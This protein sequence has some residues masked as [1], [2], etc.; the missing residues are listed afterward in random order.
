MRASSILHGQSFKSR[1]SLSLRDDDYENPARRRL[2]V[3]LLPKRAS[4]LAQLLSG[5]PPKKAAAKARSSSAA[6]ATSAP[7]DR[8]P[9]RSMWA[10]CTDVRLL[11]DL[12]AWRVEGD[13][14]KLVVTEAVLVQLAQQL[15]HMAVLNLHCCHVSVDAVQRFYRALNGRLQA[16][17][18]SSCGSEFSDAIPLL[19]DGLR[20]L[21]MDVIPDAATIAPLQ[22]LRY[23]H[24]A[25]P[26]ELWPYQPGPMCGLLGSTLRELSARYALRA[27]SCPCSDHPLS[28]QIKEASLLLPSGWRPPSEA[29]AAKQRP[30]PGT[31]EVSEQ[32]AVAAEDEHYESAELH[33]P[34]LHL[35]AGA[36]SFVLDAAVQASVVAAMRALPELDLSRHCR[37]EDVSFL[38]K[39]DPMQVLL[40]CRLPNLTRLQLE[41]RSGPWLPTDLLA[42]VQHLRL[43]WCVPPAIASGQSYARALGSSC[44]R[45]PAAEPAPGLPA[46]RHTVPCAAT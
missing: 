42:R 27:I 2:T 35:S 33:R 46:R 15:P 39:C 31:A 26:P 20:V 44:T 34:A 30:D 17:L 23:F 6:A 7:A 11:V 14:A 19:A 24:C 5:E 8:S 28:G 3:D 4:R 25:P 18:L 36:E 38:G 9:V 32:A 21:V 29:Q 12:D 16:L 10:D 37:L 1:A 41:S 45:Q 40:A 22:Q 43:R 13:A